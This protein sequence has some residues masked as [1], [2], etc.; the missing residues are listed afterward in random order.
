MMEAI[1]S[2]EL[3]TFRLLIQGSRTRWVFSLVFRYFR[4][5]VVEQLHFIYKRIQPFFNDI[6]LDNWCSSMKDALVKTKVSE[7]E[8]EFVCAVHMMN[9]PVI[10]VPV[11]REGPVS[12][13][14]QH[15]S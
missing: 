15:L 1:N 5:L 12:P 10:Q 11:S 6:Y 8:L 9:A 13:G 3:N 7:E 4:R 2:M 14:I